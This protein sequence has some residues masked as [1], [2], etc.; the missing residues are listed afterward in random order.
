M[1]LLP[2][3][4]D[5]LYAA[6][7]GQARRRLPRPRVGVP[8]RVG[9]FALTGLSTAIA[10]AVAIVVLSAHR[11]GPGGAPG[12]RS[13]SVASSRTEL[14]HT[15]AVLRTPQTEADRRNLPSG[16]LGIQSGPPAARLMKNPRY[17][18]F[19]RDQ[20]NPQ[21]ERSL[22]RTVD[23]ASGGALTFVPMTF[24]QTT[25]HRHGLGEPVTFS[26]HG[27]RVEGLALAL[28]LPGPGTDRVGLSPSTV[29]ALQADGLNLFTYVDHQNTGVIVV[30]DG[31]T[32]VGLSDFR[33]TS[34]VHV[35]PT[36]IPAVTAAVHNNIA[37]FHVAAPTVMTHGASL[38][39]RARGMH[40]T[41]A[42]ARMTWLG[43]QGQVLKRTTINIAFNFIAQ[44]QP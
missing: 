8:R 29:G 44:A 30:P 41:D 14:L 35:D 31:I 9:T 5:H 3:F 13:S 21:I 40:S 22:V 24:R 33:V 36:L 32:N 26:L 19:L 25:P 39:S 23:L 11:V 28:R 34:Q 20:G 38:G 43:P 10:I 12:S 27:P 1:T 4:H 15:L 2:E 7:Q 37:L 18:Q 17:R 16:F 42:H 6:A